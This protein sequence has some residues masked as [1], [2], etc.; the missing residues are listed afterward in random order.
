MSFELASVGGLTVSQAKSK[1]KISTLTLMEFNPDVSRS[2]VKQDGVFP[3][4]Y[5]LKIPQNR[6]QNPNLRL[7]SYKR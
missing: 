1:F 7:A 4:R 6:Q 3:S 5:K 2:F